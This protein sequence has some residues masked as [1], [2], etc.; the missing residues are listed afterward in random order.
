MEANRQI[1][2]RQTARKIYLL[3]RRVHNQSKNSKQKA[4]KEK[5]RKIFLR[6][7]K[8][9]IKSSTNSKKEFYLLTRRGLT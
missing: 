5:K 7:K 4:K 8:E 9:K 3:M 6:E 1:D 2:N